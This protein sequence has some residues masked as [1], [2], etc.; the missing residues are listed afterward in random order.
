MSEP[1]PNAIASATELVARFG[2]HL[3]LDRAMPRSLRAN[4]SRR[5]QA[6]FDLWLDGWQQIRTIATRLSAALGVFLRP[7]I[8]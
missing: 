4:A 8:P 5:Q 1:V 6:H 7:Q 3:V 2:N